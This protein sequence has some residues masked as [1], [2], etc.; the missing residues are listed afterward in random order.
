[1]FDE[2]TRHLRQLPAVLRGRLQQHAGVQSA[3]ANAGWLLTEKC[4]RVILFVLVGAWVARHLG[5]VQYGQLAYILALAS[6]F[7]ILAGLGLD[8]L[9][10][11]DL[12]RDP[13]GAGPILGT[14]FRL[15]IA[16]GSVGWALMVGLTLFLRPADDIALLLAAVLGAGLV[17]QAAEVVDL[18][19]ASRSRSKVSVLPKCWAY[20]CAAA[21]KVMLIIYSAPL[22][23]FGVALLA[24]TIFIAVALM[25][26]YRLESTADRWRWQTSRARALIRHAMPLLIAGLSVVVYMR[27]DQ[28]I[29]RELA[30][31]RALGLYSAI[32]PLSQIWHVVPMTLCASL[33]PRLSALMLEDPVRY[34]QRL[35]QLFTLMAWGG[36][37]AAAITAMAAP[38]LVHWLLGP[39]YVEAV[40]VLRWH[41][42]CNVFVFL[43]VAQS[44]VI[45][46]SGNTGIALFRTLC[47]AI[48]SVVM[49]LL[50]VPTWGVLGAAWAAIAAYFVASVASNAIGAPAMLKM[51]LKAFWPFH[52]P[53]P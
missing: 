51:Q 50:L 36:I 33:L 25:W 21:V 49:N 4:L 18:W 39:D 34:K 3:L 8:Q 9:V 2:R 28:V 6:V 26:A 44:L 47:G 5:P 11:R 20:A 19:L 29:L 31:Q 40:P 43:G 10:V 14:A 46:N 38:I 23:A 22:W 41:A 1:M 45:I 42:I 32:L 48:A 37:S 52:V 13:T 16:A 53:K 7:Q 17:I 35:Q 24:E 27:I 30:G 15:R 12:A